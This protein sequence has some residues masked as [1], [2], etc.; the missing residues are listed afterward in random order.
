MTICSPPLGLCQQLGDPVPSGV[1][2]EQILTAAARVP[3]HKELV[4][5][6]FLLFQGDARGAFGK[7]L[8]EVYARAPRDRRDLARGQEYRGAGMGADALRRAS[9]QNLLI[10]ATALG[11]GAQWDYR[12][13]RL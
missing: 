3:G 13:V 9:C 2:I 6:R 5:W 1:E 4:A 10:A 8:A 11:Y 7:V 12:V